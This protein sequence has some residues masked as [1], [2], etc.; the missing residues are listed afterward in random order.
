MLEAPDRSMQRVNAPQRFFGG[1]GATVRD[2]L[3]YREL[4]GALVRKELKVKY[5]DSAL[6]FL[7]SLLLPLVQLARL[8]RW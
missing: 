6:G 1:F 2:I 3:G 8:L 4:L 5:K 7:W